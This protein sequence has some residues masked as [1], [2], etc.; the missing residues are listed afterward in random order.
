M[1]SEATCSKSASIRCRHTQIAFAN[2]SLGTKTRSPSSASKVAIVPSRE[3]TVPSTRFEMP[4]K[5]AT[6]SVRGRS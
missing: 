1:R 6:N 2:R 3:P 5:F 4:R